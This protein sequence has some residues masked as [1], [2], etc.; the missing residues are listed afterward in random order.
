MLQVLSPPVKAGRSPGRPAQAAA[1]IPGPDLFA[2]LAHEVRGVL[3]PLKVATELLAEP[4]GFERPDLARLAGV[5]Y[6]GVRWLERLADTLAVWALLRQPN[7]VLQS[8]PVDADEWVRPV[9]RLMAPLSRRRGEQVRFSCSEPPP[10]VLGDPRWLPHIPLNLLS[11]AIRH[12]PVGDVIE[13]EVVRRGAWVRLGVTDHGAGLGTEPGEPRV[14]NLRN[15]WASAFRLS[16][17]SAPCTGAGLGW[18]GG[19]GCTPGSGWNCPPP[20]TGI[21]EIRYESACH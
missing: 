10:R 9:L 14:S 18:V 12:G 21:M 16:A 17:C 1:E 8:Q 3:S 4:A 19:R 13:V 15:G 6:E 11:N 20:N 5:V 2:A 7:F